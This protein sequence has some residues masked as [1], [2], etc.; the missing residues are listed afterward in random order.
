LGHGGSLC[1]GREKGLIRLDSKEAINPWLKEERREEKKGTR[2]GRGGRGKVRIVYSVFPEQGKPLSRV[3]E[4]E[5]SSE[6]KP[7]AA[8][9]DLCMKEA[10]RDPN[11]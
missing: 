11:P 4:I 3:Q 6:V 5:L 10:L 2:E 7:F 1:P 8:S 9:M